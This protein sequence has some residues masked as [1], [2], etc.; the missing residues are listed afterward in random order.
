MYDS[1][2]KGISYTAGFFILIALAI[3]G[4]VIGTMLS[5]PIWTSMTGK[6]IMGMKD[7]LGNPAYSNAFKLMQSVSTL[8]GFLIPAIITAALLNRKPYNLLGFTKGVR[9]K[10]IGLVFAIMFMA[11]FIS[12]SF[13]YFNQHIPV[14]PSWKIQFQ[15]LEDEYNSQVQAIMQLKTFGDYMLGLVIMG[16]LP[17]LCEETLFRGGLQNF[18]TRSTQKPWLAILIVSVLFSA[19]HFSFYGFLPRML[20]GVALGL[21][22][23]YTGSLWL[24]IL[25]HFFNNAIAVSQFYFSN[26]ASLK[27]MAQENPS[28]PLVYLGLIAIPFAVALLVLLK[29]ISRPQQES[30]LSIDDIR[31]KAPWEIN[32]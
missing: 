15:K 12:T 32:N 4:I 30:N 31:D 26:S 24:S 22:Y 5:I 14:S 3:A 28:L 6:S 7:E 9:W 16:L 11:L 29:K 19:V 23:Y 1:N 2:S 25:A 21:I 20:L 27:Q 18:L 13:G 8:F 10:Q 17:A